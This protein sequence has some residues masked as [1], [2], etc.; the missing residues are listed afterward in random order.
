VKKD[1]L[2]SFVVRVLAGIGI[3]V[4]LT[5]FV[6]YRD[7]ALAIRGAEYPY[8]LAAFGLFATLYVFGALRWFIILRARG[9]H[10]KIGDVIFLTLSGLFLNL[11]CP[12]FIAQDAYRTAM[13]VQRTG[14]TV[15]EVLSSVMLDRISGFVG[16]FSL[17]S[18]SLLFASDAR[19]DKVLFAALAALGVLMVSILLV[20]FSRRVAALASWCVS[21][22]P[23][24]KAFLDSLTEKTRFFRDHPRVFLSVC[25][26]SFCMHFGVVVSFFLCAHALHVDKSLAFFCATVPLIIALAALPISVGGL[27]TREAGS[28]YFFAKAGI[29]SSAAMGISLLNLVFLVICALCGGVMYVACA[30]RWVQPDAQNLRGL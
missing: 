14:C 3:L 1:E 12:S 9:V 27:G 21:W 19:D 20:M 25:A 2:L 11:F 18:F 22:A 28:V 10:A 5:R 8:L 30:H 24:L 17:A 29:V 4:V 6:P 7:V 16:L 26:L 15:A 13:L 23:K